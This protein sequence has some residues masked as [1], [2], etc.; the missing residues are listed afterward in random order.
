M[1]SIS[2][3][4]ERVNH[5]TPDYAFN[6]Y[7]IVSNINKQFVTT[8]WHNETE[9]IFVSEGR[10]NVTINGKQ[11]IAGAGD[12]IIINSGE[13]HEVY[14]VSA[15]LKYSAMVFDF[16]MLAFRNDDIT[17]K[18]FI[19]PI[20]QGKLQFNN[21]AASSEEAFRLLEYIHR[22]NHNK[23]GSYTLNTKAG[24]LR[25]FAMM[26]DSNGYFMSAEE[27]SA[28]ERRTLLKSI[29]RYIN[30]NYREEISLEQIAGH[31]NMSRKYFCRFFKSHFN[32]TFVEYL[33]DVRIE[34][35]LSMLAEGT[36]VT[37]TAISC[38]FANMSYFARTFKS[39]T[40]Q[41]PSE[42]KKAQKGASGGK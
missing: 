22:I 30:N 42:Y 14:G 1:K 35:A 6:K 29:V 24:L 25:F 32:K 28:D 11:H 17:E 12:I 4:I 13:M 23:T 9:I 2:N 38:G 41:T 36:S 20:M 5:G 21:R 31:F 19:D 15:P 8:H 27:Q 33:N 3:L 37:E 40:G 26:I 16:G 18:N 34:Q 7:D 10:I 39:K